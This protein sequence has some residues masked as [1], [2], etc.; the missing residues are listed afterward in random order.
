MSTATV[1]SLEDIIWKLLCD[2]A[3]DIRMAEWVK[4]ERPWRQHHERRYKERA[5]EA[6]LAVKPLEAV[7][8]VPI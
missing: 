5:E 8:P 4:A 6:L 2:A 7:M 1:D 3:R